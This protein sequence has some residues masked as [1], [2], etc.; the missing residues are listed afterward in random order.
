VHGLTAANLQTIGALL[1]V[2][3]DLRQRNL[4]TVS[5]TAA[6]LNGTTRA[7]SVGF[8]PRL[9]LSL[10]SAQIN[11]AGRSYGGAVTGFHDLENAQVRCTGFGITRFSN[12]DWLC[13]AF[14]FTGLCQAIFSDAEIAPARA[15]DLRVA[16]A[17][18]SATGLSLQITRTVLMG[19]IA[20]P[21]FAITLN[22]FC[23][24]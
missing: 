2:D 15:E 4:A 13:R 8:M 24:G 11:M 3:Y 21:N 12:T 20:L 6:D 7:I 5:F 23:M 9:V 1:A 10:G 14:E 22:L 16:V 18:V 17:S 19:G